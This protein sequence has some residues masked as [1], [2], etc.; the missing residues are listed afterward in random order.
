MGQLEEMIGTTLLSVHWLWSL[1]AAGLVEKKLELERV[2]Q[3]AWLYA[4]ITQ[5]NNQHL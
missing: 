1:R 4:I 2:E 5:S 3:L